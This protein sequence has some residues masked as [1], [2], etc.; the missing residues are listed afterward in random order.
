LQGN[1]QVELKPTVVAAWQQRCT[2]NLSDELFLDVIGVTHAQIDAQVEST[3]FGA[4]FWY[5]KKK[6]VQESMTLCQAGSWC[7]QGNAYVELKPTRA[8][9]WY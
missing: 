9:F 7:L 1:T 3:L 5:Q 8:S 6:L 4:S 2:C